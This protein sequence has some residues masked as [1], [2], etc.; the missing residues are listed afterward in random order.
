MESRKRK[1][2]NAEEE[3]KAAKRPKL[4]ASEEKS[5][6]DHLEEPIKLLQKKYASML[7]PKI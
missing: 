6:K 4:S 7:N 5:I 3:T 1:R 2:T